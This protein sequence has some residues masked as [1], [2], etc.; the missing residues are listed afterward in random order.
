MRSYEKVLK[1]IRRTETETGLT[2]SSHYVRKHY[3]TGRKIS[4]ID[5][6]KKIITYCL[7]YIYMSQPHEN[8]FQKAPYINDPE[9]ISKSVIEKQPIS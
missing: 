1:F 8:A 5:L 4:D 2:V 6:S 7:Y 9:Q 3:E